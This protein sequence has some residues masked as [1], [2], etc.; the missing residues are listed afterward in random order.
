MSARGRGSAATPALVMLAK[1]GVHAVVHEFD[2][3]AAAAELG[4]GRAAAL[5]LGVDEQIVFKTLLASVDGKPTVAVVPVDGNLSLKG[6]AA[7][8]GGKKA[9]MLDV[10]AA[11]RL[12]GYVVGGISPFGQR[13]RL[14]TVLDISAMDHETILVSGGRRGLDVEIPPTTLVEVLRALVAPI[15]SG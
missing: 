15:R 7:A 12:T 14:P 13:T 4:Y 9:A 3:D 5:A 10:T 8:C 1:A 6:L 11:Q 2:V